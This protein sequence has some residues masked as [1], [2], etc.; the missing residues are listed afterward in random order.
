[1]QNGTRSVGLPAGVDL[2]NSAGLCIDDAGLIA[3][4]PALH[5]IVGPVEQNAAT[6]AVG[7]LVYATIAGTSTCIAG[8]V[9]APYARV[10]VTALGR[11][12]P[13]VPGGANHVMGRFVPEL[14]DGALPPNAAAG[15]EITVLIYAAQP[16]W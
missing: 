3:V 14:I 11:V 2:S 1:M 12:I 6:V 8:A 16:I 7:E 10:M 5:N 15:D 13:H 4:N 9:I